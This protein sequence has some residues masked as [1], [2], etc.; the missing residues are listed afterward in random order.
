VTQ[1]SYLQPEVL[2]NDAIVASVLSVTSSAPR[3]GTRTTRPVTSFC[4]DLT[5][6]QRFPTSQIHTSSLPLGLPSSSLRGRRV[7]T[8]N[9]CRHVRLRLHRTKKDYLHFKTIALPDY[10]LSAS[11][12]RIPCQTRLILHFLF[13]FT[14]LTLDRPWFGEVLGWP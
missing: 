4:P 8:W 6:R 11:I 12:P 14:F 7:D 1:A 10:A 9:Y 13:S 3:R 2:R 5:Q